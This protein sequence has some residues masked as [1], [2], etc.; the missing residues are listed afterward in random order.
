MEAP[1]TPQI[2]IGLPYLAMALW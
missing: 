1:F 2:Y